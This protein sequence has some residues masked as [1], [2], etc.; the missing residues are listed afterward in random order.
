MK[1]VFKVISSFLF[2]SSFLFGVFSGVVEGQS[3]TC[4][5]MPNIV[6]KAANGMDMKSFALVG[7]TVATATQTLG[8]NQSAKMAHQ[9]NMAIQGALSAAALTKYTKCKSAI[10]ECEETC[11]NELNSAVNQRG[12]DAIKKH[13][14]ECQKHSSTCSEAG[15]QALLS[16]MQAATSYYASQPLGDDC[17]GEDCNT[18]SSTPP[19]PP[20]LKSPSISRYAGISVDSEEVKEPNFVSTPFNGSSN[21][22]EPENKNPS[23]GSH[24]ENN[25]QGHIPTSSSP[26]SRHTQPQNLI[27]KGFIKD[28]GSFD[29]QSES[30][31]DDEDSFAEN[32]EPNLAQRNLS[33]TFTSGTTD[34][35]QRRKG[36][37]S[38][39]Y[40]DSSGQAKL[41]LNKKKLASDEN[42]KR[43][44]FS[45]A[46]AHTSIFE[47]M[48]L[49]IQSYCASGSE[50]C[51]TV[52]VNVKK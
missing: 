35:A 7:Q 27:S 15:L 39:F 28:D 12:V 26:S 11:N 45:S 36:V 32:G 46:G 40:G 42:L 4:A 37:G 25:L 33:R 49:I 2:F 23:N 19:I 31:K 29:T 41:A 1:A 3:P 34:V 13:L 50:R 9:G 5:N 52:G 51:L 44:I 20:S 10:D 48:S 21:L 6:E 17:E 30:D 43:D 16:A 18:S 8:G 24:P 47:K 14:A 38:S 22:N